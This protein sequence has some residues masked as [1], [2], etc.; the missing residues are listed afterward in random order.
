MNKR[1][2]NEQ[3][4]NDKKMTRNLKIS[5]ERRKKCR[6]IL[7]GD[8]TAWSSSIEGKMTTYKL[9]WNKNGEK[10]P[11]PRTQKKNCFDDTWLKTVF[12]LLRSIELWNNRH[13]F[14]LTNVRSFPK[15]LHHGEDQ[16]SPKADDGET[17]KHHQCPFPPTCGSIAA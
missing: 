14:T 12:F 10:Q 9:K 6:P 8:H 1:R 2:P 4:P 16:D 15:K 11:T 3:N 13:W 5:K 17:M 7:L